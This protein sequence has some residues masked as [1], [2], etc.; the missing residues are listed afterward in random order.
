MEELL[1]EIDG[2]ASAATEGP[3][4]Y[5]KYQMTDYADITNA[6]RERVLI[7]SLQDGNYKRRNIDCSF[8]AHA[9]TDVP[10][11]V[12]VLR[13]LIGTIEEHDIFIHE[14]EKQY[15]EVLLKG[16]DKIN[17]SEDK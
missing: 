8:I 12:K 15:L 7:A 6:K 17:G 1:K 16:E 10:R 5:C 13:Y 4:D 14:N 2:R 9:R 3:W 11:L